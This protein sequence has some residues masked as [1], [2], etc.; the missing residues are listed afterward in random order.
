MCRLQTW[1]ADD[2]E[3]RLTAGK[4]I[5]IIEKA[6]ALLNHEDLEVDIEHDLGY[7]TQFPLAGVEVQGTELI[8]ILQ[9]R[10][11]ACL[12]PELCC[13]PSA[14]GETVVALGRRRK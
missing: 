13:P 12:A 7:V 9:G 1:V 2:Y 4:L 3:H 11:T 14:S 8:L 6:Q 10:N 5:K